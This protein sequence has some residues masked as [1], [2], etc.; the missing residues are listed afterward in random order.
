MII[1]IILIIFGSC[2]LLAGLAGCVLPVIP[3]P[4]LSYVALLFLQASGFADFS[5]RFLVVA[6]IITV[7]VTV[8]DYLIPMLGAKRWGGS[9]AGMTGAMI[10][11]IAG[12]FV[13]PAGIILGPFLG[14]VT[15]ELISGRDTDAALKSGMGSLIGF[16]AG[17]GLKLALCLVLAYCFVKE[18]IA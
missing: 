13:P 15:A 7:A 4:P 6:A 17:M 16:L 11:L 8:L 3:G 9:K 12:L 18:L 10:G 1:D 2:F 5:T 14:A